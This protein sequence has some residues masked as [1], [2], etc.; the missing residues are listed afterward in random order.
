MGCPPQPGPGS[1]YHC[2]LGLGA[3]V[4]LDKHTCLPP[5]TPLMVP[6]LRILDL[7]PFVV[8]SPINVLFFISKGEKLFWAISLALVMASV[9]YLLFCSYDKIHDIGWCMKRDLQFQR[10]GTVKLNVLVSG[11]NLT[12]RLQNT[13]V[14][15]SGREFVR[16]FLLCIC[17]ITFLQ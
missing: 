5:W 15:I 9:P 17:Y 11:D 16:D 2:R 10:W 13:A 7:G 12:R 4:D 6:K 1:P 3:A 8:W 14:I